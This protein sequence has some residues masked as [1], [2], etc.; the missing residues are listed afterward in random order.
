[1]EF[2]KLNSIKALSNIVYISKIMHTCW[3]VADLHSVHQSLQDSR[4]FIICDSMLH[5]WFTSALCAFRSFVH[6]AQWRGGL[7][8]RQTRLQL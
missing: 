4:V 2:V 1:M 8:I 5:R 6:H 7:A 3:L